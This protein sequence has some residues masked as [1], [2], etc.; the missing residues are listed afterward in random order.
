MDSTS[1]KTPQKP[2]ATLRAGDLEKPT[3]GAEA[4]ELKSHILSMKVKRQSLDDGNTCMIKVAKAAKGPR[5]RHDPGADKD[6]EGDGGK[7]EEREQIERHTQG[8]NQGCVLRGRHGHS[9][10]CPGA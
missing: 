5:G 1:T 3:L 4:E 2:E 10:P 8:S 7:M 9:D 6:H